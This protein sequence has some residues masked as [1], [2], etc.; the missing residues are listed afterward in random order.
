M[1]I[2]K[3]SFNAKIIYIYIYIFSS[4]IAF[5]EAWTQGIKWIL[6]ILTDPILFT[7]IESSS[8]S[9][10][11]TSEINPFADHCLNLMPQLTTTFHIKRQLSFHIYIYIFLVLSF[12]I[13]IKEYP[14]KKINKIKPI[15]IEQKSRYKTYRIVIHKEIPCKK[16]DFAHTI[17]LG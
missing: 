4:S 13:I 7:L 3:S 2:H 12:L 14:K 9:F 1:S 16:Y 8:F 6:K 5:Y 15:N 11:L 17:G 10:T